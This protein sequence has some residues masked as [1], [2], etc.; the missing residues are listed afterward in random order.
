MKLRPDYETAVGAIVD[1][2]GAL[3]DIDGERL[4]IWGRSLG[5]YLAPRAAALDGRLRACI[6]VGGLYDLASPWDVYPPSLRQTFQFVWDAPTEAAARRIARDYTLESVL[7]RLA[8]PLLLVH[9]GQDAFFSAEHAERMQ[10]EA[11]DRA[12]LLVFPEGTHACDNIPT[13]VRPL[14]ADWM[15]RRLSAAA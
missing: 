13:L 10:R 7:P 4:G 8:C 3:P 2:L 1:A 14:M 5:G 15:A 12:E 6:S 11:G 9:S